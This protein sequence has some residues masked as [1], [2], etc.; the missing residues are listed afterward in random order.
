[1]RLVAIGIERRARL[2]HEDDVGLHRDRAGDAET[3]L[4]SARQA[5]GGLLELVLDLAPERC[6]G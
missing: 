3:L 5:E 2:V 4:L 6:A 1:M